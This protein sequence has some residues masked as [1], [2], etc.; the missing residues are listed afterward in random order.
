MKK[1]L[2]L[3]IS[4]F[5]LLINP[6]DTFAASLEVS[7]SSSFSG[8]DLNF[9]GGETV[10]VRLQTDKSGSTQVLNIK[11]N[12]YSTIKS[13]N[14]N[15]NGSNYSASFAAPSSEGYYSLE[16]KIEGSGTSVTSVKT[17]KVGS[18]NSANI[19][20]NVNSSVRG[21]STNSQP[22]DEATVQPQSSPEP[23]NENKED[24]N[25]EQKNADEV[26]VYI[27]NNEEPKEREN[28]IWSTIKGVF[29]FVWPF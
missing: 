8:S 2:P 7:K 5:V 18:P 9:S 3:I 4:V 21:T 15:K 25:E 13:V 16:A 10:H 29:A 27:N 11:D 28:W 19:K 14:L 17:I 20:V 26:E 12:N 23:A 6:F 24:E 22:K 1:Y